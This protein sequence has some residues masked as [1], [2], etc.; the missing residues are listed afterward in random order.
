MSVKRSGN[1][2]NLEA[3]AEM[4]AQ[5]GLILAAEL[6]AQRAAQKAPVDTGRLSRSITHSEPKSDSKGAYILVGSN[7]E[8]A[9]IV[10]KGLGQRPQPYLKPALTESKGDIDR[11]IGQAIIEAIKK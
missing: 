3:R 1:L 8:Y 5:R 2:T 4:G 6:V 9:E 7:V 10:E 11:L